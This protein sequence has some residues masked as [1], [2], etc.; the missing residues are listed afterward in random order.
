M[1]EGNLEDRSLVDGLEGDFAHWHDGRWRPL[2][3]DGDVIV[4]RGNER[5]R[6]RT[7]R[8]PICDETLTSSGPAPR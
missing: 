3:K 1:R 4:H 7:Y 6:D 2:R 5:R 8:C